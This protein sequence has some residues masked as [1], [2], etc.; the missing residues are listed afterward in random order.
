MAEVSIIIPV[1]NVAPYIKR[2]LDSVVAQTFQ[3]IE[4]IL[5]DDC[6]TDNSMIIV[7]DFIKNYQGRIKFKTI[8]HAQ[9]S[10]LSAARNTGIKESTSKYLYFLDSDDSITPDCIET[11]FNLF[12]KYPGISFGQGNI[13]QENGEISKYGFNNT[14]PEFINEKE[15]IY[16]YLLSRITTS[17][18]NRL[19]RRNF[20]IENSLYFPVGMVH[21]DMYW[22][23][24]VAKYTIAAA[25][26]QK[27]T[28][29]YYTNNG[30]IMTSISKE[31]RIERYTSRLDASWKY[32]EDMDRYASNKYQ[33]Q[34]LSTNLLSCLTEL[35]PLTSFHHWIRFWK[36]ILT[37]AFKYH[38]HFTIYRLCF[39]I[40]L[41]P[42]ACFFSGKKKFRWHIQN[43]IVP[44]L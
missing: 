2:C 24:F 31:K 34:H 7:E 21:E 26:S 8:H 22:I 14:I 3:D 41:L 25:F 28:Y 6:A 42:P 35:I 29:T 39:L 11:L 27:G 10:G 15:D 18:W 13:L 5:V 37:M 36:S 4:C 33:R 38:R 17:A 23:Y 43:S 32:L 30:S 12:L 40:T 44:K 19:I 9:N 1:Y 20:I 16:K